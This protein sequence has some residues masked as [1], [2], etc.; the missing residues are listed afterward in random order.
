MESHTGIVNARR[1]PRP[2]RTAPRLLVERMFLP[3]LLRLLGRAEERIN[4]LAFSFAIG[5]AR[6]RLDMKGAPYKIARKLAEMKAAG[7]D[8]RVFMEGRRETASRNRTTAAFLEE[9]GVKVRWGATHAKGFCVDGRY[10][11]LGSTNMTNQSILR[12]NETNVLVDDAAS[13]A[14]QFERYFAFKWKGGEHGGI[15]LQPPL[16]ADAEFLP[17]LLE[18][19]ETAKSRLEFSI[20]F[21]SISDIEKALV[22]AH[23]RGVKITGFINQHKSFAL[24]YVWRTQ[25]TVRRLRSAGLDGLYFDQDHMFTHSKYLIK[26]RAEVALGTGNWLRED[27]IE[28]PQLYMKLENPKLARELAKHLSHQIATEASHE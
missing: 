4:V 26:D 21:F 17:M 27:V 1:A 25:A 16:Y 12:N 19:I 8:V 11:L 24:P 18:M 9:A 28:H 13:A 23:R 20:Y 5:S 15:H 2:R 10:L 6:G 3:G 22:R 14:A 7:V